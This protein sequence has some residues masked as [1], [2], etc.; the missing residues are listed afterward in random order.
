MICRDHPVRQLP[1]GWMI[2]Q[3][4]RTLRSQEGPRPGCDHRSERGNQCH[5]GR[6]L[7]PLIPA[8]QRIGKNLV[9]CSLWIDQFEF[10]DL[11][12]P[13]T[14]APTPPTPP[15]L[16]VLRMTS[17]DKYE[18]V[19]SQRQTTHTRIHW[20]SDAWRLCKS[21]KTSPRKRQESRRSNSSYLIS[22]SVP[23]A[24]LG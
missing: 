22:K 3:H 6:S 7:L 16:F 12:N 14:D 17:R 19:E 20:F 2:L 11:V 21:P 9:R 23:V 1:S 10:F 5:H 15:T 8:A 13:V 18:P 4:R 24:T